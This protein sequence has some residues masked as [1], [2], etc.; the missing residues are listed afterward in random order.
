MPRRHPL[1]QRP[2]FPPIKK[3]MRAFPAISVD[4]S[5]TSTHDIPALKNV[6]YYI[7]LGRKMSNISVAFPS[8]HI[9]LPIVMF[10]NMDMGPHNTSHPFLS[11]WRTPAG[12][13]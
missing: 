10:M 12:Q 11:T 8:I 4:I 7:P 1:S 13:K 5:I 6:Y 9:S 2:E 3:A